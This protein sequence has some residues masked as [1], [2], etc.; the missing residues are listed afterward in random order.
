MWY[1]N[2]VALELC[3]FMVI[4]LDVD[5]NVYPTSQITSQHQVCG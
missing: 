3:H 5:F 2:I 1:V 4:G